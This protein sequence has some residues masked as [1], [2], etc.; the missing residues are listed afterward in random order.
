MR[1][2]I[3]LL[4]PPFNTCFLIPSAAVMITP[5]PPPTRCGRGGVYILV[6]RPPLPPLNNVCHSSDLPAASAGCWAQP[7]SRRTGVGP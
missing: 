1:T 6:Y 2:A 7:P 3:D 5:A 4:P